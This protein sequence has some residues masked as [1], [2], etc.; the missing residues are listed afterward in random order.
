MYR[1]DFVLRMIEMLGDLIAGILGLLKEG[2]TEE[3]AE[4]LESAY[5]DFLKEDAAFFKTIPTEKLTESLL[6]GHNYTADHLEILAELFLA[7]A[8]IL[9]V[10]NEPDCAKEFYK[11]ALVLFEYVVD[12][13]TTFSFTHQTKLAN[14]K[15][16]IN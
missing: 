2:K 16:K 11:K 14:I 4:K 6:N 15:S 9:D 8:N 7:E 3:A 12:Q 10:K 5:T 1:K 13:S